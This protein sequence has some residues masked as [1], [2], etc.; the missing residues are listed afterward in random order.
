MGAGTKE[1]RDKGTK[2]QRGA[3]EGMRGTE[4]QWEGENG[5]ICV[6]TGRM[7]LLHFCTSAAVRWSLPTSKAAGREQREK[8]RWK[9]GTGE[10][11]EREGDGWR[12]DGIKSDNE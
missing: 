11:A 6:L 5:T 8:G 12:E 3:R 10:G 7:V 2:G 9:V 1:W 4:R